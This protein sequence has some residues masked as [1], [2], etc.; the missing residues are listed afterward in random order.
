MLWSGYYKLQKKNNMFQNSSFIIHHCVPKKPIDL[1]F[2]M[3]RKR[4]LQN[5]PME[6][7][8]TK[9]V[10]MLKEYYAGIQKCYEIHHSS[11]KS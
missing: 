2:V 6:S 5:D 8:S 11:I 7:L 3:L 10:T 9:C 4:Y 1:Q